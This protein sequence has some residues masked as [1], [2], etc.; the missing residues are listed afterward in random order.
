MAVKDDSVGVQDEPAAGTT[1][2]LKEQQLLGMAED[3][4]ATLSGLISDGIEAE[5]Y[6]VFCAAL[7]VTS[8]LS[9]L[10]IKNASKALPHRE[11]EVRNR[12][13]LCLCARVCGGMR[14]LFRVEHK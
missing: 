6:T 10:F 11:F 13:P 7:L 2:V 14:L 9:H 12:S 4:N 8:S 1:A 3:V 5:K